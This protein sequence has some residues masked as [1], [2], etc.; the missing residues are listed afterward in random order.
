MKCLLKVSLWNKVVTVTQDIWYLHI[1]MNILWDCSQQKQIMKN[2]MHRI[3]R[4]SLLVPM[5]CLWPESWTVLGTFMN[6]MTSKGG[7]KGH[8]FPNRTP[9]YPWYLSSFGL[10]P[11]ATEH[12]IESIQQDEGEERHQNESWFFP[13]LFVLTL[14]VTLCS[15]TEIFGI[16][17]KKPTS[18]S[19]NPCGCILV[20]TGKKHIFWYWRNILICIH[21]LYKD[22]LFTIAISKS[23]NIINI[24]I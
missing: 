23:L 20:N 4:I 24:R 7:M 11:P 12:R 8:Q 18:V 1:M 16:A 21:C 3:H 5:V 2:I 22:T 17:T 9:G 14:V 19:F 10:P 13:L 15:F 6:F